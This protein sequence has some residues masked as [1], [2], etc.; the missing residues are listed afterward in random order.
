MLLFSGCSQ[1]YYDNTDKTAVGTVT[2]AAVGGVVGI[3][4]PGSGAGKVVGGLVGATIGGFIGN[5]IGSDL[6]EQSR[7]RMEENAYYALDNGV[8][9][10]EYRWN[11]GRVNGHT[12]ITREYR[13]SYN[14]HCRD[15]KQFVRIG[16]RP[17]TIYG[18]A[19]RHRGG[20]W[21]TVFN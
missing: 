18:T 10:R 20:E 2:G 13:N 11:S 14:E 12:I 6:D 3:A 19:C 17:S 21:R 5:K 15:F 8:V 1:N 4:L 16:G 7:R 9:D